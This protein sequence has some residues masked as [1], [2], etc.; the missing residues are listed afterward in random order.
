MTELEKRIQH[1]A[2]AVE[3]RIEEANA[4]NGAYGPV[5]LTMKK[6]GDCIT[7]IPLNKEGNT[8][9]DKKEITQYLIMSKDQGWQHRRFTLKTIAQILM[10]DELPA[11]RRQIEETADQKT[12]PEFQDKVNTYQ[13]R[14]KA[15]YG[16][17][18]AVLTKRIA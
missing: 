8:A 5:Y 17:K 2:D 1:I 3:K 12:E 15:I 16:K 4:K 10:D 9:R 6:T 11:I 7:V 18:D 13:N 14:Y